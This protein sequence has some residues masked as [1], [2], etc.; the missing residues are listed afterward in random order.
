MNGSG[1]R[2]HTHDHQFSPHRRSRKRRLQWTAVAVL[3][4]TALVLG[5]VGFHAYF[6]NRNEN[7]AP[8]DLLYLTLQ[9][10]V[11]ESGSE[12]HGAVPLTLQVARFIAPVVPVWAAVLGLASVFRERL[13]TFLLRFA[14]NHTVVCG[15]GRRGFEIASDFC[16]A[17]DR[18]VV[19][20][21]DSENEYV[22]LCREMGITV[23]IGD[24]TDSFV[25][26][27]ARAERATRVVA[28]CGEDGCNVEVGVRVHRLVHDRPG[29]RSSPLH[30][31]VHLVDRRLYRLFTEHDMFGE[32]HDG[33][34]FMTFN[35]YEDAADDLWNRLELFRRQETARLVIIGLGQMGTSVLLRATRE[36]DDLPAHRLRVC[37]IDTKGQKKQERFA[38]RY[39]REA[40]MLEELTVHTG[41]A[42]DPES[43]ERIRTWAAEESEDTTVAICFDDDARTLAQAMLLSAEIRNPRVAV[44]ARMSEEGGLETLLRDEGSRADSLKNVKVFGKL[45]AICCRE[46]L[47]QPADGAK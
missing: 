14:K 8:M 3:A 12:A 43:L 26:G 2:S 22:P 38:E 20:E 10:F 21:S 44:V 13:N 30:C 15:L 31:L 39:P 11:L 34:R 23:L 1:Q 35:F 45:S 41:K 24:A 47:P 18:V 25:L 33:V 19:I 5:L 27:Q 17:G 16:D 28:V 37:V 9:L 29:A 36:L 42:D 7:R 46:R 40:G 32:A 4:G 6:E